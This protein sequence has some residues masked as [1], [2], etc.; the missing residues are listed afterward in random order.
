MWVKGKLIWVCL[1][2]VLI[3]AQDRCT[4]CAECTTIIGVHPMELLGDVGQIEACF[5]PFGDSVNLNLR[6]MYHGHGNHFGHI[7]WHSNMIL[8]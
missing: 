5:G 4:V 8:V 2:I 7:Q 6:R 1:E 3:S